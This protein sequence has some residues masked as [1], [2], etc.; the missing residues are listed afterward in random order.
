MAN[1]KIS[2][3]LAYLYL[4]NPVFHLLMASFLKLFNL[5][6]SATILITLKH[7][8]KHLTTVTRQQS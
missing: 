8:L 7:T 1:I 4:T 3:D 5:F 2:F 6:C